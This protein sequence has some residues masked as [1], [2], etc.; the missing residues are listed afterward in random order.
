MPR[1][2][3]QTKAVRL[4]QVRENPCAFMG[5][6]LERKKARRVSGPF[7]PGGDEEDRTPDLRIANA[8]LSQLSYVPM[9]GEIIAN[10]GPHR[11][12]GRLQACGT[13]SWGGI[14]S[15]AALIARSMIT[16]WMKCSLVTTWRL[17]TNG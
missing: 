12:P 5:V 11:Q 17:R 6:V 3:G 15:G 13:A 16:H 14:S 8:A 10:S 1:H 7:E 9:R 4:S 2:S